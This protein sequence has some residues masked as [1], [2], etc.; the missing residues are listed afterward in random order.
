MDVEL[1]T[2]FN[3]LL[4]L[5]EKLH[6]RPHLYAEELN[7][8]SFAARR[9]PLSNAQVLQDLWVLYELDEKRDGYFVEFGVCDGISF[10]NTLL[11]EKTFGWQGAVAE[12]ARVWHDTL[13]RNRNCYISDKC[14]HKTDGVTIN[15]H[16]ADIAELSALEDLTVDDFH[17][18]SRTAGSQYEV[19]TISL[20]N[21]LAE[22]K[23]PKEI[24][25]LSIDIEG[26]ELDVISSFDFHQYDVKL[27]SVEHNFSDKRQAI[28]K[29]LNT[30]GYRR[31]F[32]KLSLFD[33]WYVRP[34]LMN[35]R[36]G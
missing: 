36:A 14:V 25:Y 19:E 8:L 29:I 17:R 7:F 34:D 18:A 32:N 2:V 3:A 5:R 20:K 11:L 12:P 4:N 1:L 16:E 6:E 23:A 28:Y 26:G 35:S 33:D 13:Y 9:A 15:F 30:F 31:K 21:F 24:D 27:I 10:S 22:A